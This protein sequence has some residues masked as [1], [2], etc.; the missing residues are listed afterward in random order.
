MKASVII[1]NYNNKNY[2]QK[3]IESILNQTYQN[4][5]IIFYDDNSK[6]DSLL[7]LKKYKNIKIIKNEIRE[8]EH[9]SYNQLHGC[10]QAIKYSTGDLVFL[11]DSDDFFHKNKNQKIIDEFKKNNLSILFDLPFYYYNDNKIKKKKDYIFS[12]KTYWPYIPPQS[13]ITLKREFFIEIE[14]YK[15]F[16]MFPNIW[17]DFR[18]GI[19]SKYLFKNFKIL[20]TNLTYYRQKETS[21]SYKFKY[22]SR[23]WWKRR[24]EAHNFI[25]FFFE[26]ND[27]T[28]TRNYDYFLTKLFN[29]F[30]K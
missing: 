15:N 17:M 13:C 2:I 1:I 28:Y 22:L 20:K 24:L 14:K 26:K 25:K 21:E 10:Y 23:N 16:K 8:T 5:E 4:I 11:L 9:G 19:S 3:C 12:N 18:I 29:Y 27:I 30:M 6:D 7:E